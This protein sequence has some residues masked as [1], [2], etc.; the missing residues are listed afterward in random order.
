MDDINK[1]KDYFTKLIDGKALFRSQFFYTYQSA[2][3]N[4]F[5]IY[6][7]H[8][9]QS[10]K[11]IQ[12]LQQGALLNDGICAEYLFDEYY[13][14]KDYKNLYMWANRLSQTCSEYTQSIAMYKKA[15]CLIEGIGINK[16]IPQGVK[17]LQQIA[18][19]KTVP[20]E[21]VYIDL[22]QHFL[23][24]E[25]Y[26]LVEEYASKIKFEKFFKR[27]FLGCAYYYMKDYK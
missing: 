23:V 15:N 8:L 19:S 5:F 3:I 27:Y 22:C 9:G 1:S 11:A 10:E 12:I 4:M 16:N 18:D 20:N 25:N 26:K 7:K 13:D 21:D 2:Y 6:D 14:R 17:I 24:K